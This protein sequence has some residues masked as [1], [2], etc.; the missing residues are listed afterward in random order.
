MALATSVTSARV[1][2]GFSIIDSKRCVATI[3]RLPSSAQRRTIF[4]CTLGS[5]ARL[6][7]TPRSPR[8]TMMPSTSCKIS[9]KFA[10][11][12]WSS[13]LPMI[14]ILPAFLP[15]SALSSRTSSASRTNDKAIKSTSCSM[16]K[17]IS[18]R[19]L[20]VIAGRLT[21]MPGRLTWRLLFK[22][23]PSMILQ[24]KVPLS[25]LVR[26]SRLMMPL[27]TVMRSPILRALTK[28]S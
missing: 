19:S 6:I 16:P 3:T 12:D 18:D 11:P 7:S 4:R 28:S 15:R 10:T 1:G 24:P 27:S 20:L 26:T 8:A 13:I 17:A 22:I 14:L 25:F 21:R 5:S 23:P 9:S 2:I